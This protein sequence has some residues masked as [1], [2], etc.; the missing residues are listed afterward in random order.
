MAI[1]ALR[2]TLYF[3]TLAYVAIALLCGI[4]LANGTVTT[5]ILAIWRGRLPDGTPFKTVYTD[6]PLIDFP[7]GVLVAFFFYGTNGHDN[8]YQVFLVDAY[9]TLQSAFIWLYLE[10]SRRGVRRW[11][12]R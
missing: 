11:I 1:D 4:S 10:S 3:Y 12:I 7:I 2:T 5:L 9:S 8:G 6:I